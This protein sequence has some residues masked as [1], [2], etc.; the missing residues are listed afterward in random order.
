M[1]MRSE[2][3]KAAK[4]SMLAAFMATASNNA[5]ADG[6]LFPGASEHIKQGT[7]NIQIKPF[8]H[9]PARTVAVD[10]RAVGLMQDGSNAPQVTGLLARMFDPDPNSY[11]YI[12][13]KTPEESKAA[14]RTI[15]EHLADKHGG[16]CAPQVK[17][18]RHEDTQ[19][20]LLPSLRDDSECPV[21]LAM[22]VCMIDKD[23]WQARISDHYR[24]NRP[25]NTWELNL[26]KF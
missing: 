11:T 19:E 6:Y 21:F 9:T 2:W 25:K 15:L 22:K 10:C 24:Y 17:L 13:A 4:M 14:G 5:S 7:V 16:I 20:N 26:D 1:S 23:V 8:G 3:S 18:V 12:S